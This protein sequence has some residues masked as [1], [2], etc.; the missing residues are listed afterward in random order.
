[1]TECLIIQLI[2]TRLAQPN[3]PYRYVL[4][5]PK[6]RANHKTLLPKDLKLYG[7]KRTSDITD[8]ID[9]RCKC[10][11]ANRVPSDNALSP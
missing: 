10:K 6:H 8:A 11:I 4:T 3:R 7:F 1:M 9:C 2:L 5:A